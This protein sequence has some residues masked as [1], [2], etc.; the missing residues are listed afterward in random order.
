MASPILQSAF[1][2]NVKLIHFVRGQG[3][4]LRK[5]GTC[6]LY[7]K[8]INSNRVRREG[9]I[10]LCSQNDGWL[11]LRSKHVGGNVNIVNIVAAVNSL[12]ENL[13]ICS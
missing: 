3:H 9:F 13:S 6:A 7:L 12:M 2:K 1:A 4:F 11:G 10:C 5:K 8:K